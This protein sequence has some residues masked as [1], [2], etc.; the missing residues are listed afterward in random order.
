LGALFGDMM[1]SWLR[2]SNR[3]PS[4]KRATADPSSIRFVD[5]AFAST[6]ASATAWS[7][8]VAGKTAFMAKKTAFM[9]RKQFTGRRQGRWTAQGDARPWVAKA[10]PPESI[11][12]H[13]RADRP[14]AR[15]WEPSRIP[16]GLRERAGTKSVR[17]SWKPPQTR[18]R[19]A[20]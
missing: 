9:A 16:V 6:V 3:R 4:L 14:R 10:P 19:Q 13:H 8:N 1:L 11:M 2:V 18:Q 17:R 15:G 12:E 5:S 7:M 20:L